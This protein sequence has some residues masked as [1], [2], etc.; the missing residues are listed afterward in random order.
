[1]SLKVC[2]A[3]SYRISEPEPFEADPERSPPASPPL[4]ITVPP[5]G[6][7]FPPTEGG[8]G[9][10]PS[11]SSSSRRPRITPPSPERARIHRRIS[12]PTQEFQPRGRSRRGVAVPIFDPELDDL[13]LF[14]EIGAEEEEISLVDSGQPLPLPI[15]IGLKVEEDADEM[16][17]QPQDE[18]REGQEQPRPSPPIPSLLDLPP[19]GRSISRRVRIL[20]PAGGSRMGA[21][22]E[23]QN[24]GYIEEEIV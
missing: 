23:Y 12:P 22:E 1:M 16:G 24:D 19:L 20:P 13:E 9:G 4:E 18:G 2:N 3:N 17:E 15:R 7:V 10:Q 8:E 6:P 11:P 21:E 5:L 14:D